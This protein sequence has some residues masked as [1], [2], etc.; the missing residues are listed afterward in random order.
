MTREKTLVKNTIIF[1]IGNFSS[2][3][4]GFFL[5][6]FYTHYFSA[7]DYGYFD[8]IVTTLS[9]LVPIVSFQITDG[10]YR[11]LL[12]ANNIARKQEVISNSLSIVFRNIIIANV[13]YLLALQFVPIKYGY[14]IMLQMDLSVI[15]SF[16]FQAARGM[17]DNIGY[18][19]SGVLA[20]LV[21]LISNLVM[22]IFTSMRVDA[23]LIS[24][25]L[26]NIVIIASLEFRLKLRTY[27]KLRNLD[28]KLKSLLLAYSL[29][30]IPNALS[31]WFMSLSDRFMINY[32]IGMEANGIYAIANKF[33]A[34]LVMV[35]SMFYLA[36]QESA[37]S[38]YNSED[39]NAFY[40]SLFNR[41]LVLQFTAVLVLLALTK[42]VMALLVDPKF[43]AAWLYI[44]F[45]Y[46]GAL[47][48]AFSSFYG[49]GYLS[50][51]DTMGSFYTSVLGAV[52][53][54]VANYMLIPKMGIQAASLS[55]M[56]AFLVMWIARV[57]QTRRYFKIVVNRV[58]LV[59]LGTLLGIFT[60]LYYMDKLYVQI[61]LIVLSFL[62]FGFYNR[63]LIKTSFVFFSRKL[64]RTV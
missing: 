42:P 22:V 15:A 11:Y 9:L 12:D 51:K 39:R 17:R 10:L 34:M 8:L 31:W 19:V 62:L 60:G 46:I 28:K 29:P 35:Y 26:S 48:S 53:N 64:F 27:I 38:E 50:A 3:L 5:L 36:W 49:T 25:I 32:Y 55:T 63:G 24:L 6:P 14:L 40:T 4:L 37:I 44:P 23:L 7:G 16:W 20:T 30:L 45:L 33:P 56:L 1:A 59:V 52:V 57:Y 54:I 47:F 13:L 58:N 41:L 18:S 61:T 2:K 21:V 43:S